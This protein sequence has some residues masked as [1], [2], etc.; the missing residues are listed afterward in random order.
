VDLNFSLL[1]YKNPKHLCFAADSVDVSNMI[2]ADLF[3]G[4][5]DASAYA[6]SRWSKT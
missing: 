6:Y 5:D 3:E 1:H 2:P 4:G